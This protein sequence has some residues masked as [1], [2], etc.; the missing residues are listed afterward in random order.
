[1]FPSKFM[2]SIQSSSLKAMNSPLMVM[3]FIKI[4]QFCYFEPIPIIIVTFSNFGEIEVNS[5][6]NPSYLDNL[7][8]IIHCAPH[9][10]PLALSRKQF[11][12]IYNFIIPSFLP[13]YHYQLSWY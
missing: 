5:H 8:S 6:Q 10:I 11:Y 12:F 7:H 9:Q 3:A 13:T 2:T 1:M 4:S